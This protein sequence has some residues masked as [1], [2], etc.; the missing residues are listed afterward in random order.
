LDILLP[1]NLSRKLEKIWCFTEEPITGL[2]EHISSF[3]MKIPLSA[4]E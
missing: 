3:E 2:V 4:I 1:K